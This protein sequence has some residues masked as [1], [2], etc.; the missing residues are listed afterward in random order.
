MALEGAPRAGGFPD[1]INLEH[2]PRDLGPIRPF[3]IGVEKPQIGDEVFLVVARQR[4]GC[5]AASAVLGVN[6]G[7]G[8]ALRRPVRCGSVQASANNLSREKATPNVTPR[9]TLGR[10]RKPRA[11]D[12][13]QCARLNRRCRETR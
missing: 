10:K 12:A 11:G 13:G 8:M 3:G 1:R 2:D 7:L 4:V 5:R 9:R 6:E